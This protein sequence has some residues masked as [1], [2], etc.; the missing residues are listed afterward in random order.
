M[1]LVALLQER[2]RLTEKGVTFISGKSEEVF[3]SY[4]RLFATSR[5]ALANLQSYGLKPQDKLILQS[6]DT[7]QFLVAFWA[8]LLGGI[9]PVPLTTSKT[10][11]QKKKLLNVWEVTGK[12][13]IIC[14]E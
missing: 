2:S 5:N 14:E 3:Y 8:C 13:Y 12:P 4:Q 7:E 11:D 9:I 10:D 1:N 6:D